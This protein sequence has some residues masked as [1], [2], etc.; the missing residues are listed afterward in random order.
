MKS[1]ILI[2][3]LLFIL[4]S[5]YQNNTTYSIVDYSK[6]SNENEQCIEIQ[7]FGIKIPFSLIYFKESEMC[8]ILANK[9]RSFLVDLEPNFNYDSKLEP[10]N[11]LLFNKEN[12]YLLM[13]PTY[14]EEFPTFQLV[15]FSAK[16]IFD[17]FGFHTFSYEDI[18]NMNVNSLENICYNIQEKDN[19]PRI[20]ANSKVLLS[21]VEFRKTKMITMSKNQKN[22]LAKLR[23]SYT[24]R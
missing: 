23:K 8:F 17:N 16:G 21:K 6:R 9:K 24:K 22:Q 19:L 12:D 11:L 3:A 2:I 5:S 1:K 4:T 13:L 7:F 20:Y 10:E 18:E 15:G 14:S